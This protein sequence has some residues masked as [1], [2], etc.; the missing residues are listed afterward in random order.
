MRF[1]QKYPKH[2]FFQ[3]SIKPQLENTLLRLILTIEASD[4]LKVLRH[5][6]KFPTGIARKF[7]QFNP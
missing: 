4:W 5:R 7:I 1:S 6:L 2:E 3:F